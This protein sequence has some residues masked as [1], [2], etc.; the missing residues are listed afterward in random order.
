MAVT[1]ELTDTE[2]QAL[3]REV[4][5]IRALGSSWSPTADS[6]REV[7]FAVSLAKSED[8][9]IKQKSGIERAK[10]RGVTLRR[11]RKRPPEGFDRCAQMVEDGR[12]S[13]SAAAQMMGVSRETYRMWHNA[14]KDEHQDQ[15][16]Q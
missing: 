15:S 9:L 4:E 12:I 1:P 10:R 2:E 6:L 13:R 5:R 16:E 11:P 14:W 7:V 3:L 8:R